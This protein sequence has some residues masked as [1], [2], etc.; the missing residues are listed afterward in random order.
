MTEDDFVAWFRSH[1]PDVIV[2]DRPRALRWLKNLGMRVPQDVG[3]ALLSKPH[4]DDE[5]SGIDESSHRL[6]AVAVD[7]LVAM[8]HQSARGVP[9]LT[10]AVLLEGCW[11]AGT[12][13]R[14]VPLS[15][16]N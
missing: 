1:R 14:A 3:H 12:T 8:L 9:A 5:H 16:P 10:Q 2:A 4:S 6:G 7:T 11:N 13:V 15:H